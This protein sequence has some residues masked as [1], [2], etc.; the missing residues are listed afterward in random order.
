MFSALC[1]ERWTHQFGTIVTDEVCDRTLKCHLSFNSVKDLPWENRPEVADAISSRAWAG[2]SGRLQGMPDC[3][4][5][6]SDLQHSEVS[7][8]RD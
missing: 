7:T 6:Y 4:R 2:T 1:G 3:R 5:Y 8:D